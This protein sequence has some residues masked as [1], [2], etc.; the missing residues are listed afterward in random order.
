MFKKM[1][2]GERIIF[3]FAVV[4]FMGI[5]F[6]MSVPGIV[7]S[8]KCDQPATATVVSVDSYE[9]E[10]METSLKET[11]YQPTVSYEV[12]GVLYQSPWGIHSNVG[13][14]YEGQQVD[15]RY[16]SDDPNTFVLARWF[17]LELQNYLGVFF[18]LFVLVFIF[19]VKGM[20]KER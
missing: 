19:K 18:I 11:V 8:L 7:R 20:M 4:L 9:S 14:L 15:I 12:N 5:G 10:D 13:V 3:I 6:I 1:N 2:V 17:G 16:D